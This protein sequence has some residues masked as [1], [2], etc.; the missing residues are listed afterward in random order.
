MLRVKSGRD[1]HLSKVRIGV[2]PPR[3]ISL[4]LAAVHRDRIHVEVRMRERIIG[5][6]VQGAEEVIDLR[7]VERG[8]SLQLVER[9]PAAAEAAACAFAV[10]PEFPQATR[11]R[12]AAKA[13]IVRTDITFPPIKRARGFR[14]ARSIRA[15]H[16][17]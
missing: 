10:T 1:E 5:H 7:R 12:P 8:A 15:A 3:V 2:D 16:L 4:G 13:S 6:L 9:V 14:A 17:R 11:H